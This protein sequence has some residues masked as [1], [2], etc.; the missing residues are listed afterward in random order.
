M[1]NS[2]PTDS[3]LCNSNIC[4]LSAEVF[5]KDLNTKYSN[6]YSVYFV[7]SLGLNKA[8]TCTHFCAFLQKDL[9]IDQ[10]K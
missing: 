3:V 9:E 4:I 10:M 5:F 8:M 1:S 2:L 7:F 6:I